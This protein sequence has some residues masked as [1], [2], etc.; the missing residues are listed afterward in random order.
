LDAEALEAIEGAFATLRPQHRRVR[1]L[2]AR[3]GLTPAEI[4]AHPGLS[5]PAVKSLLFRARA[6]YRAI[7]AGGPRLGAEDAGRAVRRTGARP[8]TSA[9]RRPEHLALAHPLATSD[10]APR[11]LAGMKAHVRIAP[12]RHAWPRHRGTH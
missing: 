5:G 3:D 4:A 9:L 6:E 1:L 11:D 8:A 7:T 10:R 12:A 2:R